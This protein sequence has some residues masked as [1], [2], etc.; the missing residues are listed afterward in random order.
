MSQVVVVPSIGDFESVEIIEILVAVGDVIEVEQSLIT[1]ESDKASMDIPSP[2]AGTVTELLVNVGEKVGIGSAIVKVDDAVTATA[3]KASDTSGT[4]DKSDEQVRP[5]ATDTPD[6]SPSP[7]P[8]NAD[9]AAINTA[10]TEDV[11]VPN[12]GDFANIEVIEVLVA[13]GDEIQKEQSIITLESDKA[14]MDVPSSVSGVVEKLLINVGDKISEGDLMVVVRPL[15]S[16]PIAPIAPTPDNTPL[17]ASPPSPPM[18]AQPTEDKPL[19]PSPANTELPKPS[20]GGKPYAGPAVRRLARELGVDL[21]KI[22]GSGKN[23]RVQKEDVKLYV[24]EII[25]AKENNTVATHGLPVM[26]DIDFTQFGE[27]EEK[28]LS[29]INK[30]SASNLHRNW[31][32]APHVTQLSN[33]DITDME[34]FRQS[35]AAETKKQGYKMTPL[36]FFIKAAAIALKQ[37]PRFNAS[38]KAD[39]ENLVLKKYFNI[40]VAVDTPNGLVVPVLRHV[41]NKGIADIARELSEISGLARDGKLPRS[42]MQGGCFTISSLGGIGGSHFTPIINLPEV[43]IL[44]VGRSN[45]EPHWDGTAFVPRLKLPLALSYDHRVV[46]GA[47]GARF[48]T[49][50]SALLS[51]IRRLSV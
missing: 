5:A 30:L 33:A 10:K 18:A 1:L 28:K 16:A 12:I 42:S 8:S 4:S 9:N 29:R 51:D 45:M 37:F 7:M 47:E 36:A 17:A 32:L 27:V 23:R 2:C 19:T 41:D 24:K 21:N 3:A 44:G 11:Y 26:A 13:V 14:S 6:V 43:A 46:D 15:A 40:G 48:I 39:G 38:L 34:E 50:Y 25:Q 22:K 20:Y 35:L 49:Y 31:L